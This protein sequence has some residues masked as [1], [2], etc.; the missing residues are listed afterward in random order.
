MGGAKAAMGPA[1]AGGP[2]P[3]VMPGG[4]PPVGRALLA[5]ALGSL[6]SAMNSE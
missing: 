1:G 6:T 5:A 4:G 3:A 2:R